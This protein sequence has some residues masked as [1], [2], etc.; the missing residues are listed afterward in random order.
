MGHH[1]FRLFLY[2]FR[3]IQEPLSA[4]P[5]M[6]SFGPNTLYR[7]QF[8]TGFAGGSVYLAPG[9][10]NPLFTRLRLRCLTLFGDRRALRYRRFLT[11]IE[12]RGLTRRSFHRIV[13]ALRP[14]GRMLAYFGFLNLWGLGFLRRGLLHLGF[15]YLCVWLVLWRGLMY[16]GYLELG[17][18]RLW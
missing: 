18:L 3:F 14:Q 17:A 8:L 16:L 11:S 6:H 2:R 10:F 1:Q 7:L 5:D 13:L 9:S 15:L 4:T 12:Y